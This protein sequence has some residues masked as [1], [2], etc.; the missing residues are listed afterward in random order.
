[1]I[2]REGTR[3]V[4]GGSS[5]IGL[6]MYGVPDCMYAAVEKMR[7]LAVRTI[8]TRQT[9]AFECC[10]LESLSLRTVVLSCIRT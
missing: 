3:Y 4:W 7:G 8:A 5:A 6:S 1:M 10:C 2:R 9:K